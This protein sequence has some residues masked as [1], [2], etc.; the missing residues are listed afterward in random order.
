MGHTMLTLAQ[1]ILGGVDDV[2]SLIVAMTF[3]FIGGVFSLKYL[4][5]RQYSWVFYTFGLANLFFSPQF[6]LGAIT[7]FGPLPLFAGWACGLFYCVGS[8]F[9][10]TAICFLVLPCYKT[11]TEN[12]CCSCYFTQDGTA[13]PLL[14]IMN[15]VRLIM[16]SLITIIMLITL[17]TLYAYAN[18]LNRLALTSIYGVS[19]VTSLPFW[20]TSVYSA[21]SAPCVF[22]A[23]YIGIKAFEATPYLYQASVALCLLG[24]RDLVH[25]IHAWPLLVVSAAH[26]LTLMELYLTI[27]AIALYFHA[28]LPQTLVCLQHI[29]FK[30]K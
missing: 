3:T 14:C 9:M 23:G 6:W 7:I 28:I 24:I 21:I 29:D 25:V 11:Y 18:Q 8:V 10:L 30:S 5:T 26:I 12:G 22:V 4:V 2:L 15:T 1:Q 19:S 17:L 27:G 13:P 16:T 20:V